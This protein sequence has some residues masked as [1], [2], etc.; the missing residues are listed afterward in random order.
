MARSTRERDLLDLLTFKAPKGYNYSIEDHNTQYYSVWLNHE[1][2]YSYTTEKVRTIWGFIRKK[3]HKI[4][5]PVNA[6]KPGK[7]VDDLSTCT[8]YSAMQ[9]PSFPLQ[10]FFI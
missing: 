2:F 10:Q 1:Q 4:V 6:K 7:I 8:A 3:D 5:R 9:K